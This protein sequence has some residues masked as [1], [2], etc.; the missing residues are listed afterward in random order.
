MSSNRLVGMLLPCLDSERK[1]CVMYCIASKKREGLSS[2]LH[3]QVATEH[4]KNWEA[5]GS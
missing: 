2:K 1:Q 3:A 4:H 5:A